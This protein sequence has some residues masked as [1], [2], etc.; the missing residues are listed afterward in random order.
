MPSSLRSF[1][2]RLHPSDEL[3]PGARHTA[4]W[5]KARG[6]G[7]HHE[8]TISKGP[9]ESRVALRRDGVPHIDILGQ[10]L[11]EYP[12]RVSLLRPDVNGRDGL[13]LD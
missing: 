2:A 9:Q 4:L 8:R 12:K 5:R 10:H 7:T 11:N 13:V 6:Q 3:R 1:F